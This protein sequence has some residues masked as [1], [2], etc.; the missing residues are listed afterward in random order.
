M[1]QYSP[2]VRKRKVATKEFDIRASVLDRL[3]AAKRPDSTAPRNGRPDGAA[4]SGLD[5]EIK[6]CFAACAV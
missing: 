2:R 1:T 3:V 5:A 6:R 4:D